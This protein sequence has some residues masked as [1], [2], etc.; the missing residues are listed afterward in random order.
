MKK[1]IIS[2]LAVAVSATAF[3]KSVDDCIVEIKAKMDAG[4]NRWDAINDTAIENEA[5]L[6]EHFN[7]WV[8]NPANSIFERGNATTEEYQKRVDTRALFARYLKLNPEKIKNIPVYLGVNT[9]PKAYYN[10]VIVSNPT[11][12]ED[13]K[14][15]D[16]IIDEK[17]IQMWAIIQLAMSAGDEDYIF[18]LGWKKAGINADFI[19]VWK[20]RLQTMNYADAYKATLEAEDYLDSISN[21]SEQTKK[22]LQMVRDYQDKFYLRL[23][24]SNK[25][26]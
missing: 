16:F 14:K 20:N 26:K 21:P 11:F 7:A 5:V 6:A 15:N 2:I 8:S 9:N 1:L 13:L 23:T 17:R 22:T 3:S 18:S 25:I 24:R 19:K 4:I 10:N 12:Y